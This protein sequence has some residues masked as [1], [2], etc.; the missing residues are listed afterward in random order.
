MD[1]TRYW[2]AKI[3]E[4][5][6]SLVLEQLSEKRDFTRLAL[7]VIMAH[8][9]AGPGQT[10]CFNLPAHAGALGALPSGLRG[11][12]PDFADEHFNGWIV[13]GSPLPDAQGTR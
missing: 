3:P 2:L 7:D 13:T 1:D 6:F 5:A 8:K 12:P 10:G 9:L 4:S 11:I